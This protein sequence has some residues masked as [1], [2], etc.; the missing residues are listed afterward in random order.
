[1]DIPEI[2]LN[3]ETDQLYICRKSTKSKGLIR[4]F[5][6]PK[7]MGVI[8]LAMELENPRGHAMA[9]H[10]VDRGSTY[11]NYNNQDLKQTC[12][13]SNPAPDDFFSGQDGVSRVSASLLDPRFKKKYDNID[14]STSDSEIESSNIDQQDSYEKHN[15]RAI[16]YENVYLSSVDNKSYTEIKE[17]DDET[18]SVDNEEAEFLDQN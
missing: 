7:S 8:W 17:F 9:S 13:T 3:E 1:M 5:S 10:M 2:E 18:A 12:T 15:L 14:N 6:Y 4:Y 11:P 16:G